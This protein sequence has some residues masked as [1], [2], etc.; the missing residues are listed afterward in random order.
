MQAQL[1]SAADYPSDYRMVVNMQVDCNLL[2]AYLNCKLAIP[3]N[4]DHSPGNI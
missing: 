1:A 3:G 4:G 2:I